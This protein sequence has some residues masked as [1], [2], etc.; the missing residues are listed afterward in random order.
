MN[1]NLTLEGN[2]FLNSPARAFPQPLRP[3]SFCHK[4]IIVDDRPLS[5][6]ENSITAVSVK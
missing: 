1:Q 2:T 4:R 6:K 3:F 5:K